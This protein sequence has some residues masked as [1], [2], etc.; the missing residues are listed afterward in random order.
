LL[1]G[2]VR[3]EGGDYSFGG[4]GLIAA[5]GASTGAAQTGAGGGGQ[6]ACPLRSGPVIRLPRVSSETAGDRSSP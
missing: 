5:E 3:I 6:I 1:E 2:G 4:T